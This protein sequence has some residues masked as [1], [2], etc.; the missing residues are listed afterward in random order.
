MKPY[1][2]K[3]KAT[4]YS[5]KTNNYGYRLQVPDFPEELLEFK[6]TSIAAISQ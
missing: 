5:N 6:S 2:K 3:K 4:I 1:V